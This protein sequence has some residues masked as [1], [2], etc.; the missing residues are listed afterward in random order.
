MPLAVGILI[1]GGILYYASTRDIFEYDNVKRIMYI[2]NYRRQNEKEI[3][4]EKI[5]KILY[6]SVGFGRGSHS[7]LIIYSDSHNQKHKIRLF[8][9]PFKNDINTII[10]DTKLKNPDLVTRNW[11][12]GVNE[13]FD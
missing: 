13:L 6:S 1:L 2:L 9:I 5:E 7:Y 4:V 8:P 12:F 3:P 10:A 11:S